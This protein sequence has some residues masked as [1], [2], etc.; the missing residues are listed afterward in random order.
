MQPD[1]PE[2]GP[3]ELY[4]LLGRYVDS[5]PKEGEPNCVRVKIVDWPSNVA[6]AEV[7]KFLDWLYG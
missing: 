4:A 5:L 1:L 3:D 2:Y 7:I 6:R